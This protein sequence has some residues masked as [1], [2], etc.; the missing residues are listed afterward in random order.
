MGVGY[1]FISAYLKGEEAKTLTSSHVSDI[2]K[3]AGIQDV[4]DVVRET[5]VGYYL[6]GV[7][8]QTFDELDEHLWLY[9]RFFGI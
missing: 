8:I 9:F 3:D 7:A 1:A 2:S 6:R 5:D 4:L